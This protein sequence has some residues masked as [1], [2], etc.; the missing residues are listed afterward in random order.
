MYLCACTGVWTISR[1]TGHSGEPSMGCG[2]EREGNSGRRKVFTFFLCFGF[3]FQPF[4]S[5]TFSL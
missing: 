5:V 2:L 3:E 1:K 4:P